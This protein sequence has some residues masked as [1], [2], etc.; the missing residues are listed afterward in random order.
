M[1]KVIFTPNLQCH[2]MEPRGRYAGATV[3]EALDDV[4][5]TETVL[6]EHV[7][8]ERGRLRP[9]VIVFINGRPLQ[10]RI[11][12]S[13]PVREQSEIWVMLTS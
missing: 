11:R 7:I 8:D 13:D 9:K 10:D 4:F 3:K 1:P 6:R 12:L 5:A 2:L